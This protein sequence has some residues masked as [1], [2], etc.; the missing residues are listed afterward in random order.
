MKDGETTTFILQEVEQNSGC[1]G[2]L[3]EP[4]SET[5]HRSALILKLLT[6]EPSGAIVAAPTTSLPEGVSGERNWDY[7]FT[8]IRDAAFTLYALLRIGF[9]EE[10][11]A[12]I[13]WIQA[14][15]HELNEERLEHLKSYRGSSPVR[16]GNGACD[17]LQ[18]DIFG[19]LMDSM[20]LYNKYGS[21]I[22]YDLWVQLRRL[23]NLVALDRGLRLADKRSFP[24][25]RERWITVRDEIYEQI[26]GK[27]WSDSREAFVQSYGSEALDAFALAAERAFPEDV[28]SIEQAAETYLERFAKV[29][30]AT[31]PAEREATPAELDSIRTAFSGF[32]SAILAATHNTVFRLLAGPIVRLRSL[33]NWDIAGLDSDR[34]V[35]IEASGVRTIVAAVASGK[36]DAAR[37]AIATWFNLPEEAIRAMKETPVGA[38]V[39]V[40]LSLETIAAKQR[41]Q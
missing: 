32:T 36:P 21:P 25:D 33:R 10:A 12:F 23:A 11:K 39:D 31:M 4:E 3:P 41:D 24:A 29:A 22:S 19:E 17:Q 13:G 34:A 37:G 7:R 26:M 1:G 9:T 27:G 38:T 15:A 28:R 40:P 16:V 30:E 8:W 6:Y 5:V 14:R 18:L 35:E 20:Y 2:A